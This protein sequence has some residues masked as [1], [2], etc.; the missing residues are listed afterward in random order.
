MEASNID[1]AGNYDGVVL[2]P[3][4]ALRHRVSAALEFWAMLPAIPLAQQ[5]ANSNITE[6]EYLHY[7]ALVAASK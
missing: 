6:E 2:H 5:L 7:L 3:D 4:V 1:A